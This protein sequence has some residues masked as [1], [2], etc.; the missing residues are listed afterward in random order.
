MIRRLLSYIDVDEIFPHFFRVK[1]LHDADGEDWDF[2]PYDADRR[3]SV[4][5]FEVWLWW[6][7][8]SIRK[9]PKL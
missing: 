7:R 8:I 4:Y 5:R 6:V 1:I 9:E 3:S 2:Y